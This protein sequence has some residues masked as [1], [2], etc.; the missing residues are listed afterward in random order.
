MPKVAA[1]ITARQ[2]LC[3]F[4]DVVNGSFDFASHGVEIVGFAF[5]PIM[6]EVAA[7]F[8]N[9]LPFALGW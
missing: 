5:V 4:V 3:L 7:D 8:V 9:D 6:L 1:I 2:N